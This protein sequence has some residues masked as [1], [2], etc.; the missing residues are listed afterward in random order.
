MRKE[1]VTLFSLLCL[2]VAIRSCLNRFA[3]LGQNDNIL[4]K[5]LCLFEIPR[6]LKICLFEILRYELPEIL[7]KDAKNVE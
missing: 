2:I 4:S 6:F 3:N 5:K 7:T 1:I